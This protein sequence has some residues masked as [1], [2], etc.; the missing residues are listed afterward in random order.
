VLPDFWRL[1][2]A[3]ATAGKRPRHIVMAKARAYSGIETF[4]MGQFAR[5]IALITTIKAY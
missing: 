1:L 2:T 5:C 4:S 3:Y